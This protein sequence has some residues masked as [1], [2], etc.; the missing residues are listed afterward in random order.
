MGERKTNANDTYTDAQ[1]NVDLLEQSF[2]LLK[3]R[4]E[5]LVARFYEELFERYPEVLP[6]F[7]GTDQKQ[8]RKNYC[9]PCSWW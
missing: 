5:E 9:K 7:A 2:D 1:L 8:Q 3:G 6:L 4:G